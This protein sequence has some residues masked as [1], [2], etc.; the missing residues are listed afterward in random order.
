[1]VLFVEVRGGRGL[2]LYFYFY[3][4]DT[5]FYL[6]FM[7]VRS[8]LVLCLDDVVKLSHSYSLNYVTKNAFYSVNIVLYDC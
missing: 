4:D 1:M 5:P 6:Y 3:F 2:S 7:N 8:R